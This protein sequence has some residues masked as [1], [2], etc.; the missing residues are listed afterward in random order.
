MTWRNATRL[1]IKVG[2]LLVADSATYAPRREWLLDLSQ[3][4]AALKA[5]GIE[6]AIVTSGA[7]AL[8]RKPMQFGAQALQ[9]EE[10]QAAAACGQPLLMQAWQEALCACGLVA[11]QILITAQDTEDR[12]RYLNARQTLDCLFAAGIVPIINENDTITTDEIRYGDND[13]LAARA[14]SMM[15]ADALILFSDVDGLYDANPKL[16]PDAKK[17]SRIEAITPDIEA[18]AGDAGHGLTSGGMKTKLM[19]AHIATSSGCHMVIASGLMPHPLARLYEQDAGSWFIAHATPL[20]ARKHW[21]AAAVNLKGAVQ[22]D[23]GA[24]RAVQRGASLLPV[25]ITQ[26]HGQW[27]RGDVIEIRSAQGKKIGQGIC[28]YS[29]DE[30]VRIVG[31]QSDV[32]ERTLG[33]IRRSELIHLDDMVILT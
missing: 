7:V 18:L 8:G 1:V 5:R 28:A 22:L 30:T 3:D 20:S 13:R 33:Y 4:I 2:S 27:Q 21:I 17:I 25:G 24:S 19:A 32:I 15:S 12:R 29:A 10:K 14:A 11:A 31:I 23:E 6:V 9:L 26:C 16:V